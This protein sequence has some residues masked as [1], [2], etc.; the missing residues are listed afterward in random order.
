MLRGFGVYKLA[1]KRLIYIT[2]IDKD[3]MQKLMKG[4]DGDGD[5]DVKDLDT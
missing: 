5:G 1:L 3:K 2:I 4:G